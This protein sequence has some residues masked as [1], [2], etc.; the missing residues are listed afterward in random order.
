MNHLYR[1]HMCHAKHLFSTFALIASAC[2]LFIL[3]G[4]PSFS[5]SPAYADELSDTKTELDSQIERLDELTAEIEELQSQ[6]DEKADTATEIETSINEKRD[7]IG[8]MT[9]FFYKNP[10]TSLIEYVLS[11]DDIGQMVSRIEFLYDYV[12]EITVQAE[13]E[14]KMQTDLQAEIDGITAQKDEQDA[15][16][17]ELRGIIADLEEKKDQLE[18][19]QK[20]KLT[21]GSTFATDLSEGEW[22]SGKAS[23][24]GGPTDNA[25]NR[26]ANGDTVSGSIGVAVPMS[27]RYL[28]GR[29]I[30]VSYGGKSV[31]CVIND[32]G[33]FGGMGRALDLNYNVIAQFGFGSCNS[34]GVR[35]VK[36]RLL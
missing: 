28:L 3:F 4:M 27:Q 26:T 33:G 14:Q 30:E 7:L 24:Y 22:Q 31:I 11:S 23:A 12:D 35:T 32:V 8:E 21:T 15:A 19:E 5:L 25:G 6:I 9:V 29:K 17:E 2:F 20:A 1:F 18:E 34:W 13:E 16:A 10:S 36:Y